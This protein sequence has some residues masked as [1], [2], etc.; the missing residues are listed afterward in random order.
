MSEPRRDLLDSVWP[1]AFIEPQG[2]KKPPDNPAQ[3]GVQI[4]AVSRMTPVMGPTTRRARRPP[5][6][7]PPPS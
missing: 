1:G 7:N 6:F 3:L 5:T 4:A 2:V